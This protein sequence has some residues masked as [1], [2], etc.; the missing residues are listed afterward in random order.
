MSTALHF[1]A[2]VVVK[3]IVSSLH[4]IVLVLFNDLFVQ[5]SIFS[6]ANIFNAL[7]E[8]YRRFSICSLLTELC[9]HMLALTLCFFVSNT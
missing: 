4:W 1:E 9:L 3:V 7:K 8:I 2:V 5:W 6:L